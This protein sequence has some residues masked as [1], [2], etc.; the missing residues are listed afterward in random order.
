M[1]A[2][3]DP[4]KRER[5]SPAKVSPLQSAVAASADKELTGAAAVHKMAQIESTFLAQNLSGGIQNF[6]GAKA[7]AFAGLAGAVVEDSKSN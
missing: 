4:A 1:K 2:H 6:L 7:M 5:H 3:L